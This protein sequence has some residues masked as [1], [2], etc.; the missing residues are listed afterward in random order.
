MTELREA[1]PSINVNDVPHEAYRCVQC[2]YCSAFCEVSFIS[3]DTPRKLIRFLQRD[4]LEKAAASSFLMLCKQCQT[5][6][7]TCPRGIDVAKIMRHL[8]RNRFLYY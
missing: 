5:C 2:G 1:P 4:D 3:S 8:V 6:S 7:F